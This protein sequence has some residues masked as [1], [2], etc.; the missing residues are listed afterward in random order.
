MT[1][2]GRRLCGKCE[3]GAVRYEVADAFLYAANCHR[4]ACRAGTGAAFK[5]FA[6]IE[7]EQLEIT[8]GA[9]RLLVWG[10]P[11]GSHTRWQI[12][13]DLEPRRLRAHAAARPL[14]TPPL[15]GPAEPASAG[16]RLE[17]E[18]QHHRSRN[19]EQE[20]PEVPAVVRLVPEYR[21]AD[22]PS[23][24]RADDSDGDRRQAADR[25]PARRDRARDEPRDEAEQ[26]ERDDAHV[27]E[28]TATC[29][30]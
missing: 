8:G 19:R 6:G 22:Q 29:G 12:V 7:R 28:P 2:A 5:P 11:D 21:V 27:A 1:S 30:P 18:Q 17:R 15:P 14:L 20:R 26:E 24:E 25:L 3:C 4:S 9:D 16:E 13:G 10:E 23:E